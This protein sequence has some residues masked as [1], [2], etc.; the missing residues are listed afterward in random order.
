MG[1]PILCSCFFTPPGL[2]YHKLP[3][4]R[5]AGPPWDEPLR[6]GI[7]RHLWSL[8]GHA[9]SR[10]AKPSRSSV[11]VVCAPQPCT[12]SA[13]PAMPPMIAQPCRSSV[14]LGCTPKPCTISARSLLCQPH[15][16]SLHSTAQYSLCKAVPLR[17]VKLGTDT[18][19]RSP[20]CS[21][22][23]PKPVNPGIHSHTG[24]PLC[25]PVPFRHAKPMLQRP[26][27]SPQLKAP[28]EG[29]WD[30]THQPLATGRLQTYLRDTLRQV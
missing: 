13:F 23:P 8:P 24:P 10:P 11:L 16:Q 25:W 7:H 20:F 9:P 18:H 12:I 14:S 30:P 22:V 3:P 29:P 4:L 17:P 2:C 19:T 15:P 26:T 28:T 21:I 5:P 27:T 6:P 1:S